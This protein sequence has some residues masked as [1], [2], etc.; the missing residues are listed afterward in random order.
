MARS[1][2]PHNTDLQNA[3]DIINQIN[4]VDWELA[5]TRTASEDELRVTRESDQQIM[6]ISVL[7]NDEDDTVI[8]GWMIF[9]NEAALNENE[10]DYI[11]EGALELDELEEFVTNWANA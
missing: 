1:A 5:T 10:M 8:L 4:N 7:P 6:S 11:D 9:S 2:N 3:K